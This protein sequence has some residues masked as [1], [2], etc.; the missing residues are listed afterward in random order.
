MPPVAFTAIRRDGQIFL[1]KILT[2]RKKKERRSGFSFYKKKKKN[3]IAAPFQ[4]KKVSVSHTNVL[5]CLIFSSFLTKT[6]KLFQKKKV[7]RETSTEVKTKFP[8]ENHC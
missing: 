3:P 7:F 1:W 5:A 6:L 8:D 4:K 2:S